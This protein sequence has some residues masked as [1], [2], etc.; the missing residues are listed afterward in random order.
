MTGFNA[1][2]NVANFLF[3]N[4][5]PAAKLNTFVPT[6]GFVSNSTSNFRFLLA[7]ETQLREIRIHWHEV[8]D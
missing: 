5:T 8:W 4:A 2:S 3:D 1:L 6:T 7:G